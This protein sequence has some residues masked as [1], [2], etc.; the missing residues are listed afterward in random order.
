[1]GAEFLLQ[2]EDAKHRADFETISVFGKDFPKS[3]R[4][5]VVMQN[6]DTLKI[7]H[8]LSGNETS[9]MC[10]C[11]AH[12]DGTASLKISTGDNG[13][14]LVHCFAG[15]SQETIISALKQRGLWPANGK[16][17]VATQNQ[18]PTEDLERQEEAEDELRRREVRARLILRTA[19]FKKPDLTLVQNYLEHRGIENVPTWAL[20]L[21][22][23]QSRLLFNNLTFPAM[24]FPIGNNANGIQGVHVTFLNKEGTAKLK[25]E[26]PRRICGHLIGGY[27]I[28]NK[29][30]PDKPLIIGEGVETV[31]SACQLTGFPGIAVLSASN[32]PNITPPPCSEIIIAADNDEAG[33]NGA[34]EA[35]QK[36]ARP[37]RTLRIAVPDR[38][39]DWNNALQAARTE[40]DLEALKNALLD[41][42]IFEGTSDAQALGMEQFMELEFPPREFLLKPWL[43][44]TGLT[45]IDA[46]P[47]HGKTWLALSI[48]YAVA[49][50]QRLLGWDVERRG[51]VL[52][53]DGE[54]PGALLQSRLK[55]LGTPVPED[56]FRVLS[57]SQFE[58]QG[59]A[60]PDLGTP[61]GRDLLDQMIEHYQIDLVIL[62]SVSTL[63]RSGVDN[64]VES[65][66][67]IQDWSLKHRGRGRAVIYLHHHGR[68]GNPR[69]TSSREIVLDARIKL[70]K[71]EAL[72]AEKNTA[73][74]LE[75]AKAREFYGADAAP[76]IAYLSTPSGVVTWRRE[77]MK[78]N[79]RDQV[80]EML[81]QNMKAT[82][83]AKELSLTKGR[84]SQIMKEVR[85]DTRETVRETGHDE[86]EVAE[87]P[88]EAFG[89]LRK[90][91]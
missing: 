10:K 85:T 72:T 74:K 23:K 37:D 68:S 12:E 11:L 67:A 33:I 77:S 21:T 78:E 32:L 13:K 82:D 57:R 55:Q 22:A 36:W 43:T 35:A 53:V 40:A 47:G 28:V 8:G 65:W 30:D 62:D 31:A 51:R 79:T 64:D 26:K 34:N 59:T 18:T 24:V 54:L 5:E 6:A 58:M 39:N 38:V 3:Y 17:P 16:Q 46:Q 90:T 88:R 25:C 91:S 69:G 45:M 1:V 83:I 75:F 66:R 61:E 71:D 49:S 48:G 15:C 41:A 19:G 7:I 27:V 44:T 14:V 84:I 89:R 70:T 52:Y 60:M 63:V 56:Y 4:Q 9:G 87:I 50:G 76:M 73:F 80:K 2:H 81:S 29:T 86:F 20:A 42:E